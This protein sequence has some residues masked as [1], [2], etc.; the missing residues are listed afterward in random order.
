MSLIEQGV[1][2]VRHQ[3]KQGLRGYRVEQVANLRVGWNLVNAKYRIAVV[4][5]FRQLHPDLPVEKRWALREENRKCRQCRVAHAIFRS[6]APAAAIR[7][8]VKRPANQLEQAGMGRGGRD[9]GGCGQKTKP[10]VQV[11]RHAA[12]YTNMIDRSSSIFKI[13][14]QENIF[15]QSSPARTAVGGDFL[16]LELLVRYSA[17]FQ[18]SHLC[19]ILLANKRVAPRHRPAR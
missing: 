2:Y 7:Q 9:D 16:N 3:R 11:D 10:L 1:T 14:N 4:R 12:L 15:R 13:R 6:V 5:A 8:T 17:S 18:D 19:S